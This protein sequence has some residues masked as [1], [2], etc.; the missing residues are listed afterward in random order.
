MNPVM[1][2]VKPRIDIAMMRYSN[3][4]PVSWASE[5]IHRPRGGLTNRRNS[6]HILSASSLC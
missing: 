2:H 5:S 1:F 6:Q 4:A 3:V